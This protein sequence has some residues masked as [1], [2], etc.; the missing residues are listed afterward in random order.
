VK[1]TKQV[2]CGNKCFLKE[3]RENVKNTAV[4]FHTSPPL[5]EASRNTTGEG[6]VEKHRLFCCCC[7]CGAYC[8]RG[9]EEQCASAPSLCIPQ[10][11]PAA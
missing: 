8:G 9:K 1:G 10:Q 5:E 2:M 6:G 11:R 7:C 3:A 4:D